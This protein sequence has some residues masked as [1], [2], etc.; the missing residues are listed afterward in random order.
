M[1]TYKIGVVAGDGI[2]PEVVREGLKVLNAVAAL[3][4]FKYELVEYPWGSER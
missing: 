3:E 2:G 1:K 4:K